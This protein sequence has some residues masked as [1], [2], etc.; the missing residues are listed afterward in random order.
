VPVPRRIELIRRWY[1]TLAA[2]EVTAA[3]AL[4]DPDIEWFEAESSPYGRP[5]PIRGPEA[6]LREVW[7]PLQRD[8]ERIT[9]E[10]GDLIELPAGV[11]ALV[12]YRGVRRGSGARLD[13]QAAHV[14]DVEGDR[15]IRYRGFAD[16][17]ALQVATGADHTRRLA[18]EEFEVWSSGEV[19]RLDE[20]V[21]EDVVHH[22]PY[23]PFAADGL[24]GLKASIRATRERFSDF[25]ISVLDQVAEGDRV[26]T[27]WRATMR[28]PEAEEEVSMTGITIERFAD[29]KVVESWRSMDRLGLLRELG[30]G[31]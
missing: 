21:A 2:G 1:A 27:R 18:R 8:W 20:L 30:A 31:P 14:W 13:A 15:I 29:G 26:A 24:E 9:V 11:L 4:L 10:P 7:L 16:T 28:P 25:E 6:V 17:H 12:R 19:D 22:D 23:D 3:L 5:G